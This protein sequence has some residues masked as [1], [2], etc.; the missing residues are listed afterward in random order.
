MKKILKTIIGRK[1]FSLTE[2]VIAMAILSVAALAAM[3]AFYFMG[4]QNI[5]GD[6]RA[7]AAQKAI[8]MM[9]EL[10]GLI[11]NDQ[12]GILD[13]YDDGDVYNPVLTT[14]SGVTDPLSP[15]SGNNGLKMSRRVD[16]QPIEGLADARRVF[17]RVYRNDA[18]HETL[19]ETMS[20]LRTVQQQLFPTQSY[21]IYVLHLENVPGW[22]T[23]LSSLRPMFDNVV[24]DLQ[25][26]NPGLEFRVHYINRLSFGRDPYYT[27][28][29]NWSTRSHLL[30]RDNMRVYY[31]P[32]SVRVPKG[33]NTN[34]TDTSKIYDID[35]YSPSLISGRF[36]QDGTLMNDDGY[37]MA[38]QFNHAVRYPDE[39]RMY[40]AMTPKP[41]ISL[42][43][44]MERMNNPDWLDGTPPDA[45]EPD[46]LNAIIVNLHGELMPL[47]PMRNYSDAAKDPQNFPNARAVLH[48]ENIRY[49]LNVGGKNQNDV[50]LR[51]Y[52]YSMEPDATAEATTIPISIL[53]TNAGPDAG[54]DLANVGLRRLDGASGTA[55]AWTAED[56]PGDLANTAGANPTT[57]QTLL[58]LRNSP[59]RH[60]KNGA[61]G[62]LRPEERLYGLEYIPCQVDAGA[63][64]DLTTADNKP[65]NTAR[66]TVRIPAGTLPEGRYTV[67]TMI[68]DAIANPLIMN[69]GQEFNDLPSTQYRSNQSRTY[70]WVRPASAVPVTE[71]FQFMGDPRHMPYADVKAAHGYNW[72]FTNKSFAG[73][74]GFSR[75]VAGGNG[76][77]FDTGGDHN[78]IIDIPRYYQLLRNG[79]MRSNAFFSTLSG[80]SFYYYGL[81]GE[82]GY[83]DAGADNGIFLP[84]AAW[85]PTGATTVVRVNEIHLDAANGANDANASRL[86]ASTNNA[87]YG[88]FWLG[89]LYPDTQWARWSDINPAAPGVN[90]PGGNLRL[91]GGTSTGDTFYRADFSVFGDFSFG[92]TAT[93]RP[94]KR[95]Q[96]KGCSTFFNNWIFNH[97]T[98]SNDFTLASIAITGGAGTLL[99]QDFNLPLR[100]PIPANGNSRPFKLSGSNKPPQWNTAPYD[101]QSTMA[102]SPFEIYYRDGSSGSSWASGLVRAVD[103]ANPRN[104]MNILVNGLPAQG[105][106]AA[107]AMSKLSL[108]GLLRGFMSV[109]ATYSRASAGLVDV[110]QLP[111]VTITDPPVSNQISRVSS[112]TISISWGA[113]W[114]RW[115]SQP[116]TTHAAYAGAFT[117]QATLLYD[118]HYYNGSAWVPIATNLT[119]TSTSWTIDSLPPATYQVRVQVRRQGRGLH[120]SYHRRNIFIR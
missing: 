100:D 41:E 117:E 101:T 99:V 19:A 88:R 118:V 95:V 67:E 110:P 3:S 77:V 32:G 46:P 68:G 48:P 111:L 98:S 5:K 28:Y 12:V 54:L 30:N 114:R 74:D 112:P 71:Q 49:D 116:Y 52:S 119:A 102:G 73:Y 44:L 51:V 58:V 6:E 65:K 120:T 29:L 23:T 25:N 85:S 7:I 62:G 16:V 14:I 42:R 56:N 94:C 22:W 81:G 31:Y 1:G 37:S 50:I 83:T 113:A 17:V 61:N 11:S 59:L 69:K 10:R 115:D 18:V 39:D 2:V 4:R 66:W 21:D 105:T 89:E 34:A 90:F 79:M 55:Y 26:R 72:Y 92:G 47:V 107:S 24:D 96:E 45:G 43:M 103:P 13:E 70:F 84:Q 93:N 91:S 15:F 20:I 60:R 80:W 97:G 53:F 108:M 38:D 27:P 35:Y 75:A 64:Q 87:W 76:H 57:G 40:K 36:N 109:G 106:E 63:W 9:E 82:M 104:V 8:Q 78:A 33:G 86:I